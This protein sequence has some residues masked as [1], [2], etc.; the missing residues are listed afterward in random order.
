MG[1]SQKWSIFHFLQ[2]VRN[3]LFFQ[4]KLE[5]Q[6]EKIVEN[7]LEKQIEPM[8][9]F[10]KWLEMTQNDHFLRLNPIFCKILHNKAVNRYFQKDTIKI[11]WR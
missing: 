6:S 8:E 10:K 11:Y 2:I 3:K 7:D 1:V 9:A 5:V 4:H